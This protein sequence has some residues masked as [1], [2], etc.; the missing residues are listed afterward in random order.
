LA[1]PDDLLAFVDLSSMLDSDGEPDDK[2]IREAIAELL[3]KKPHL[4]VKRQA[5][6]VDVGQGQTNGHTASK[7]GF[8]DWMRETVK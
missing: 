2:K 1:D 8:A 7:T 6:L 5:S 4:G 3:K